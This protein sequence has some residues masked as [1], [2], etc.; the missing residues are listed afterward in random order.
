MERGGIYE[1]TIKES[2]AIIE[3]KIWER[4]YGGLWRWT[5]RQRE[6]DKPLNLGTEDVAKR[7]FWQTD[8]F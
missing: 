4:K 1:E 5:G 6:A 2:R 8:R 3:E 7:R